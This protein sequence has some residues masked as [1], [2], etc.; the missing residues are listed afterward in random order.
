MPTIRIPRRNFLKTAGCF[1][2]LPWLE[3]FANISDAKPPLRLAVV[4]MGNGVNPATWNVSGD[5]SNLDLSGSLAPLQKYRDRICGFKGL[6]NP[7]SLDGVGAHYPKMNVLSG[8]TV[9]RSTT[10]IELSTTMDQV[11]AQQFT[12]MTPIESLALGIE[13]PMHRVEEGYTALYSSN[14]SWSRP[15]RPAPKW[16]DPQKV[17]ARL[18]GNSSEQRSFLAD[19]IFTQAKAFQKNISSA[20]RN[21]INEYTQAAE[22]LQKRLATSNATSLNTAV[23]SLSPRIGFGDHVDQMFELMSFAFRSDLTRV[24]TFMMN[25]DLSGMS[26]DFLDGVRGGHHSISHHV[27]NPERLDMYTRVNTY[28]MEHMAGF[29]GKLDSIKEADGSLLDNTLVLFCSSLMDGNIHDSRELPILIAGG[30]NHGIRGNRFFDMSQSENRKLCR[31]HLA[32][33][34]KMGVRLDRFGDASTHLII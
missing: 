17:L 13:P 5:S 6:W 9:K 14:I 11:I 16:I 24:M 31:L 8:L 12:G 19:R 7:A 18:M 20:D 25:N 10:D 33:M 23:P 29:L 30:Q 3:T 28:H 26:F 34:D 4:F 32:I 2:G 15:N 1:V 22:E 27:N 21:V